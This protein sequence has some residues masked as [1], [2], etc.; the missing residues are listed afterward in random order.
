MN[1]LDIITFK[2]FN[3]YIDAYIVK[4]KLESEEIDCLLFDEHIVTINQLYNIT[5]G[6][7]KLKIKASDFEKATKIINEVEKEP[8][9]D[10]SYEIISCPNCQSQEL[11]GSFISMKNI[12]SLLV[13]L[14]SF[15]F[16]VYP[17]YYK[18]VYKC[19][20][21]G[22]EFDDLPHKNIPS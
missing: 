9:R 22:S 16:L 17:I 4:S 2:V 13:I 6:G 21:C 7:I 18:S 8:Y 15:A 5:V 1:Q 19:K 20:Q 10:S 12:L 11:Y 14:F 3:H